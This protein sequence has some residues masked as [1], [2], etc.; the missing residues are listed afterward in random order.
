MSTEVLLLSNVDKLGKAGDIVKVAAGHA[1]NYLL[2]Q[3]LAAPV[4]T[5]ALRRLEKLRKERD[6]LSRIQLTEAKAK[7]AKLDNASVTIRAKTVDGTR[8]YGSIH[9]ADIAAAIQDGHKVSVDKA[10]V[11]LSEPI[12][13]TGTFDLTLK[14]HPDLSCAIK[15]WVVEG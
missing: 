4:S 5:H 7:A 11:A 14:L 12:R 2:P 8:L 1:R 15:V 3:D 10:Q 6:E 9:A 13:E